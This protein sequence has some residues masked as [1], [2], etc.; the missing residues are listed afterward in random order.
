MMMMMMRRRRTTL[1]VIP[2]DMVHDAAV[3]TKVSTTLG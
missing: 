2:I 1:I 3:T